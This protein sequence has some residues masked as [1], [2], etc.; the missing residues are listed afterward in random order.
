[1]TGFSQP[2]L[3]A[4]PAKTQQK[5]AQV[6]RASYIPDKIEGGPTHWLKWQREPGNTGWNSEEITLNTSNVNAQMFGKLWERP[7]A[8]QVYAQPLYVSRL[9]IAGGYHDVVFIA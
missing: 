3:P 9:F 1:S 6:G 2:I 8:G 4:P 5:N 7:V